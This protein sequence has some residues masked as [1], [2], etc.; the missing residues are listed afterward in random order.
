MLK[1]VSKEL[2]KPKD[3]AS[4]RASSSTVSPNMPRPQTPVPVEVRQPDPGALESLRTMISSVWSISTL[5]DQRP[6]V[7]PFAA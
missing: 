3:A 5:V 4:A 6:C 7:S 1:D 2:A